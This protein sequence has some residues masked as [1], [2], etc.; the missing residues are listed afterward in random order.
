MG[1]QN[2]SLSG[3]ITSQPVNEHLLS[4]MHRITNA[5]QPTMK[6]HRILFLNSI[7]F[8]GGGETWMVRTAKALAERGHHVC[9]A[10]REGCPL[11]DLACDAG[12]HVSAIPMNGDLNPLLLWRIARLLRKEDIS[13][14]VANIPRDIRITAIAK[15][16]A[17]GSKLVALHQVDKPL[18]NRWNYKLTFNHMADMLVV[19]SESTRRT[20]HKNNPWIASQRIEVVPHGL[21]LSKYPSA[22]STGLRA[23]LGIPANAFL[24]G[25]VGRLAEQ[26]GVLPMLAAIDVFFQENENSHLGVAGAGEWEKKARAFVQTH[27]WQDRIHFL[28][29]RSD[30]PDL[31]SQ[32]DVLLVPSL[33]EGFGLVLIEAMAVGTP[34]I[35]SEVSSIPEIVDHE[36]N[37]ILIAPGNTGDLVQALRKVVSDPALLRRLGDAGRDK[38]RDIFTEDRMVSHYERLFDDLQKK[39]S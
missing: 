34:C 11:A 39:T 2:F 16:F 6:T 21:D 12:L 30:I 10:A 14:C 38:V 29:F 4:R 18:P 35:A 25:F 26:K 33:W 28:G 27:G 24:M 20:L 15:T 3:E 31:M 36:K 8:T 5:T 23:E 32:F 17:H 1:K 37:G 9:I 22:Q 13:I 7:K 19:N